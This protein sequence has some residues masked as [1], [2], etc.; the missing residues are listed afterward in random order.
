MYAASVFSRNFITMKVL[1]AI[2]LTVLMVASCQAY[3]DQYTYNNGR[4]NGNTDSFNNGWGNNYGDANYWNNNNL[5][6]G[7]NFWG[8]FSAFNSPDSGNGYYQNSNGGHNGDTGLGIN[9]NNILNGL[10][11]LAL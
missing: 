3:S 8:G 4:Y 10:H 7:G 1:I 11:V 2:A 9:L 5:P 6:N